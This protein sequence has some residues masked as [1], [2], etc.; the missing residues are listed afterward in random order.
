CPAG[1]PV[2][3][4]EVEPAEAILRRFS[5]AA[6]SLGSLSPE[7][8]ETLAIALNRVGGRSNSGEGG[9][10]PARLGTERSSAI[11]QVASGRF[12]VTPA[13]LASAVELQ[14]KIAQGSKP[15]EGGQL[16]GH[17]VSS[18]IARLRHTQPGVALISPPPHHDIYSIEDL[19]QLVFDLKQ[20]NPGADVTV[21]LVAEAGVGTVAAG[22]VKSLADVVTISGADGGTGASP[23]SSIKHAGAPWEL[24]LA[25]TQQ[26]LRAN[27]LRSRVRVRIDGGLKTGRDVLLAALLGADEYGFGTA[28][29]LAEGCLMVRTCHQDNCPVGIATQRED[30]RAKFT[31]TPEMVV[32]Y[33]EFVA[34]EL[35]RLLACMGM[36]SLDEAIGRVELLRQRPT[37]DP[38]ADKLDLAPLLEPGAGQDAPRCFVA[39]DPSHAIRSPLGDRLA[40]EAIGGL[41]AGDLVHLRYPIA[42]TDRAVGARLGVAIASR[43]GSGAPR[44]RARVEFQGTAGQSF[45]AFLAA[46]VE[47]RLEGAAND[48]V[49]KGMGGGRLV[50]RPPAGDAGDPVLAGNTV[51]YGATGGELFCAGRA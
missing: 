24:G 46:G 27:G 45:G 6:M 48:Y 29:L 40:A 20:A 36:R 12:G 2:P 47:L 51:L 50:I 10:D 16:P 11:K 1:P 3:L 19:A 31:G 14:I 21:K 30:L 39:A 9:E 28:A 42:N 25:E 22:V 41:D 23:L 37:G 35:R 43:Y 13:Y 8:H 33:L 17:K 44:G 5:T 34:E 15:G 18:Y 26:A 32:H 7:A 49:G 38:R 4:G